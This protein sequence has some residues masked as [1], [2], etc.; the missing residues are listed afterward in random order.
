MLFLKIVLALNDH[1]NGVKKKNAG[2]S[3]ELH[4]PKHGDP[5]DCV[6]AAVHTEGTGGNEAAAARRRLINW[7]ANSK[8]CVSL[9]LDL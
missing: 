2:N 7:R 3:Q 9:Y 6:P 8:M 5:F 1:I 4:N